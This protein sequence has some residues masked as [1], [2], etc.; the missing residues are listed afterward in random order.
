MKK[1]QKMTRSENMS[2]IRSTNTKPEILLRKALWAKGLRYRIHT[3]LPGRPDLVFSQAKVAV[4]V[5]GCFWHGCPFHYSAPRDRW[6]FWKD[7]LRRNVIRDMEVDEKLTDLGWK[8]VRIW[9]HELK[10]M[11]EITEKIC[12]HVHGN[13]PQMY[14]TETSA[15]MRVGES[16]AVYGKSEENQRICPCG[17]T[18]IR[19]LEVSGPGS[20][21][22]GSK[23]RPDKAEFLCRTCKNRFCINL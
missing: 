3:N 18:D 10:N 9:E 23:N 11:D 17:S 21:H 22:I 20:L 6:D 12:G 5:D 13:Q 15:G 8:I 2:R 1:Q 4:F 14:E 19:V 16:V 7:K